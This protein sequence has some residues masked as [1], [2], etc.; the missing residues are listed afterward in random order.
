MTG[1]KARS[2]DRLPLALLQPPASLVTKRTRE[3]L[4]SLA[5]FP[6]FDRRCSA[7]TRRLAKGELVARLAATCVN[8]ESALRNGGLSQLCRLGGR[9]MGAA[10]AW[11]DG[12]A[13]VRAIESLL[14]EQG[15][16]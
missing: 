7:E 2:L 5:V 10:L 3:A 12:A 14:Q 9:L 16:D 4:P 8:H 11:S 6:D 15:A 1:W 13:A